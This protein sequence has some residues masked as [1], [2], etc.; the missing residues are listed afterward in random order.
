MVS[1]DSDKKVIKRL[2]GHELNKD[3]NKRHANTDR[4]K[5]RKLQHCTEKSR[6]LQNAENQRKSSLQRAH[7]LLI[8]HYVVSP[9]DTRNTTETEQVV[10]NILR[11]IVATIMEKRGHESEKE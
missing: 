8:H 11:N 6:Q 3:N 9:E 2:P 5:S 1:Q 10:L 7:Q 4:G